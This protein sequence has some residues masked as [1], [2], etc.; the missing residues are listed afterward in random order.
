MRKCCRPRGISDCSPLLAV[1]G[2]EAE[3]YLSSLGQAWRE[4]E[5]NLDP[6]F[7][8]DRIRHE[9]LPLLE[10]EYNPD[11]RQVLGDA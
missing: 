1:T 3:A 8:R 10:R 11:V 9:L 5:T 7:A 4:D 6:R 2:D